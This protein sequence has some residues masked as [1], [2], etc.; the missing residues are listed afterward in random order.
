MVGFIPGLSASVIN[1]WFYSMIGEHQE[2]PHIQCSQ[3]KCSCVRQ[4]TGD[5]HTELAAVFLQ[6]SANRQGNSQVCGTLKWGSFYKIKKSKPQKAWEW[7]RHCCSWSRFLQLLPFDFPVTTNIGKDLVRLL[8][9]VFVPSLFNLHEGLFTFILPINTFF[10][11]ALFYLI[12]LGHSICSLVLGIMFCL[13]ICLW[14]HRKEPPELI[15]FSVSVYLFLV[16]LFC[17]FHSHSPSNWNWCWLDDF[18]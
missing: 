12:N 6:G 14:F 15:V 9:L 1:S 17:E 8:T 5:S 2:I 18:Q 16:L 11:S 10:S 13:V 3:H 4:E 7:K